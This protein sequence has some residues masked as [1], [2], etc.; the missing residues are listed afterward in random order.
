MVTFD[1]GKNVIETVIAELDDANE[2]IRIAVF[3]LHNPKIFDI[4]FSKLDQGKKIEIF[5]LPEDSINDDVRERVKKD[6]KQLVEKGATIYYCRWNIGD[7]ERTTTASGRW[8]SFHGKFIVTDKAAICLSANFTDQSEIDAL[9]MFKNDQKKIDEFNKKYNQLINYFVS[10]GKN[11]IDNLIKSTNITNVEKL[12]EMPQSIQRPSHHEDYWIM[13]YPT[14]LC[15]DSNDIFDKLIICP[16]DIKARILLE[17][18][19]SEAEEFVYISTESFTDL[20]IVDYLLKISEKKNIEIKILTI[21]KSMDFTDRLKKNIPK[22]LASNIKIRSCDDNLHAKLL[23]TDKRVKVSSINLNKINLGFNKRKDLWRGN[24]ETA[25]LTENL[26]TIEIA[27][28]K[29]EQIFLQ[30][31]DISNKLIE[32]MENEVKYVLKDIYG[33]NSRQEVKN[34]LSKFIFNNE[35][36]TK[37]ILLKIGKFTYYLMKQLDRSMVNKNDLLMSLIL[38]YLS[39]SKMTY[40]KIEEELIQLET[41]LDLQHLLNNLCEIKYI[42]K[43]NNFYKLCVESLISGR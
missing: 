40:E 10:P 34:L 33:L 18:L 29:F 7:P 38:Y 13:D 17:K 3:Q 1:F 35:L 11:H 31:N 30:S 36:K 19:I 25:Y 28:K 23:I 14:I 26:E 20:E 43:E 42:E 21:F 32:K 41:Q 8:Y 12:L 4:L 16:F 27:K 24:T 2:Y 37:K 9:L 15:P 5:T 6:I 22:L 39:E